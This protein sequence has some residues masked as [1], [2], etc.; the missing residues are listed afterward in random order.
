MLPAVQKAR[1]AAARIQCGNNLHQ[2]ALALHN[3]HDVN[4]VFPTNGG[5]RPGQ[6]NSFATEGSWWGF[7]DPE[8]RPDFYV[9]FDETGPYSADVGRGECVT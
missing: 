5:P 6:Q 3:H 7:D 1:E 2:I 9:D 4:G 8:A